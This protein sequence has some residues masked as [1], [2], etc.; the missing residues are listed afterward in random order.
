MKFLATNS[1][2][3]RGQQRACLIDFQ[4]QELRLIPLIL[5]DFIEDKCAFSELDQQSVEILQELEALDI[6]LEI[7]ESERSFFPEISLDFDIPYRIS[8]AIIDYNTTSSYDLRQA[9]RALEKINCPHLELRFYDLFNFQLLQDLGEMLLDS[10]IESI[11]LYIPY[12]EKLSYKALEKL[13]ADNMRFRWIFVHSTPHNYVS[14]KTYKFLAHT[15]EVI[16]D[17]SHCG[18]VHY[19]YFEK[20]LSVFVESQHHNTCLN[21]KISIDVNGYIKNC[22]SMQQSFGH[23]SETNLEEVLENPAF[24]KLWDIKKEEIEKCRGCEFRHICTD[25][26]AYLEDPENLYSAPLKCGYNPETCEWEEW[27]TNPLKEKAMQ[28]YQFQQ[29]S[30]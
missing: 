19:F 27:S 5:A 28:H 23:I 11:D 10:T 8:N 13:K 21:R 20:H 12:T 29:A 18:V 1:K 2:V 16:S 30:S 17:H 26:R 25:C 7:D 6:V 24:T 9:V 15:T 4:H 3:V 14:E 22:P